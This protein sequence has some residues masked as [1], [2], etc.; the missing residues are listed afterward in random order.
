M[1]PN[2]AL[3]NW[4]QGQGH[5][6]AVPAEDWNSWSWQLRNRITKLEE[7]EQYLELT[8]DEVQAASLPATSWRW[9]SRPTSS[10]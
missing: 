6:A 7:L 1:Y 2:D 4:H 8:P 5:W 9:Q 10:T 3:E